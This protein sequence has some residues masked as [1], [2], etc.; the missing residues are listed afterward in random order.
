MKRKEAKD[1]TNGLIKTG[2]SLLG[3][4]YLINLLMPIICEKTN[5][6]DF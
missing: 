2:L 4:E 3:N 5:I 1:Y 6:H